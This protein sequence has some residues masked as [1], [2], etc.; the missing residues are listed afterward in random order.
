MASLDREAL[1][2]ELHQGEWSQMLARH[3]RQSIQ[4]GMTQNTNVLD[5]Y[6]QML[7]SSGVAM[8]S[9]DHL[10]PTQNHARALRIGNLRC[11][12]LRLKREI[13][14]RVFF[15]EGSW[16]ADYPDLTLAG[17]GE[18]EDQAIDSLLR[19]IAAGYRDL[20]NSPHVLSDPL[21][22]ELAFLKDI[23]EERHG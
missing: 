15:E 5:A 7:L 2:L 17:W 14:V 13:S 1:S 9:G 3:S 12:D 11:A 6:K 19:L 18:D 21:K 22:A 8:S 20:A 4:L 10:L 16:I 23:I